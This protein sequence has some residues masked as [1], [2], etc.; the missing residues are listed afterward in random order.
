[1]P[2]EEVGGAD[3]MAKFVHA[4]EFAQLNVG[5]ALDEGIASPDETLSLFYGERTPYRIRFICKGNP[6]HGSQFIEDTAAE[7]FRV[8]IDA[9]LD[10]RD[11]EKR[12]LERDRLELGDVTTVNLTSTS[13]GVQN[14]VVPSSLSAGFDIRVSPKTNMKDFDR[15]LDQVVEKVRFLSNRL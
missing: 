8:V 4:T 9:M 6:G 10:F 13:G 1:M 5:L 14:N 3:G 11:E 2:E 7:K 12:R 15:F